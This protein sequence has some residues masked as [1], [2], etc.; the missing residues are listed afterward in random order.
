MLA[1]RPP[2]RRN[3]CCRKALG[4]HGRNWFSAGTAV[5]TPNRFV[6]RTGRD[7]VFEKEDRCVLKIANFLFCFSHPVLVLRFIFRMGHFPNILVPGN[8]AE[9]YLWRKVFDRNPM[10]VKLSDKIR[11]KEHIS[12]TLPGI[13]F[14]KVMWRGNNIDEAIEAALHRSGYLKINNASGANLNLAEEGGDEAQ[15]RRRARRWLRRKYDRYHGEWAYKNIVPELLIEEDVS[16]GGLERVVDLNLYVFGDCVPCFHAILKNKRPDMQ[17]GMFDRHGRNLDTRF[18]QACFRMFP[19]AY[20]L[21]APS[22]PLPADFVLPVDVEHLCELAVKVAQGHDHLRVDFMWNGR[23]LYLCE[24]TV[25][26]I[27]GYLRYTKREILDVMADCWDLR[28]S[29]FLTAPQ[30]GW[31]KRYADWLRNR[32]EASRTDIVRP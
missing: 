31:R 27:A 28:K 11:F 20:E 12:A 26:S 24:V 21:K 14:A 10:F 25:Y 2:G 1:H 3:R 5:L 17:A 16:L 13:K 23:D 22:R 30:A 8:L 19:P 4:F 18:L 6:Q 29:W 32:L 15:V 9:K 7:A